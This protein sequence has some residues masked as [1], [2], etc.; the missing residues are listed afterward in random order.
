MNYIKYKRIRET[1]DMTN[2][3]EFENDVQIFLD[4]LIEEGWNI[5]DYNEQYFT[6]PSSS[7]PSAAVPSLKVVILAGKSSN[8]IKNVL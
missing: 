8:Q 4:K 5:I 3:R 2:E 6:Y 1:F 7:N